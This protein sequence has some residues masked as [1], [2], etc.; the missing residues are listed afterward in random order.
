MI[1]LNLYVDN[2][3]LFENFNINFTYS[4]K[5][6]YTTIDNEYLE[7]YKNFKYRKVNIIMGANSSG[8]T[9]LGKVMMYIQNY[10]SKKT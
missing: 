5:L 4:K 8:K 1:F 6:R 9:S 3:F 2:I 10:L 7:G